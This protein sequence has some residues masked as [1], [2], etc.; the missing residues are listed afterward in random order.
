[1]RELRLWDADD[2]LSAAFADIEA[3]LPFNGFADFQH[4]RSRLRRAGRWATARSTRA[5]PQLREDEPEL[6]QGALQGIAGLYVSGR[7][8]SAC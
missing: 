5:L 7:Q 4:Q 1:M 8:R 2:G 6:H 3:W